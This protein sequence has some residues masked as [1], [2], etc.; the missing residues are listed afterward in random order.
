VPKPEP[1]RAIRNFNL[2]KNIRKLARKH[3][4]SLNKV[5]SERAAMETT[6]SLDF[7]SRS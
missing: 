5:I 4:T 3:L 2:L 7:L 6:F 1:A